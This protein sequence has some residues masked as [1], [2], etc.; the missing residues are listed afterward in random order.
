[1]Q[2]NRGYKD[3][4]SN[5]SQVRFPNSPTSQP[6]WTEAKLE[7]RSEKVCIPICTFRFTGFCIFWIWLVRCWN[8]EGNLLS[9]ISSP[10]TSYQHGRY[11]SGLFDLHFQGVGEAAAGSGWGGPNSWVSSGNRSKESDPRLQ[12]A[13][14][15]VWNNASSPSFSLIF[16][17]CSSILN[18]QYFASSKYFEGSF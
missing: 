8:T 1:M 7:W 18:R 5:S 14:G 2:E 11:M 10:I 3:R 6:I 13:R 16:C 12:Q 15:P 9:E 17:I 4:Q